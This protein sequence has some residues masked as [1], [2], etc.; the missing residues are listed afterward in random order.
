MKHLIGLSLDQAKE[1]LKAEQGVKRMGDARFQALLNKGIAQGHFTITDGVLTAPPASVFGQSLNEEAR[2]PKPS[3]VSVKPLEARLPLPAELS[4]DLTP[5]RSTQGPLTLTSDEHPHK[6]NEWLHAMSEEAKWLGVT[7]LT[8][9]ATHPHHPLKGASVLTTTDGDP[10]AHLIE[11]AHQHASALTGLTDMM[12]LDTSD[13]PRLGDL[14]YYRSYQGNIVQGEVIG[15]HCSVEVANPDGSYQTVPL[16]QA[17]VKK[18]TLPK[19]Y[20]MTSYL[21]DNL[22]LRQ[23]RDRLLAEVEQL[24]TLKEQTS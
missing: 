24:K 22:A 1:A 4:I 5:N 9:T 11:Q 13:L 17:S 6:L 20:P 8:L 19:P 18:K 15:F 7:N 10:Q 21:A 12:P 14:Y 23:E 2:P 16:A 3:Q